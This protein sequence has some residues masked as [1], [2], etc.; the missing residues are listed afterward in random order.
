MQQ[1]QP[2]SFD[3]VYSLKN[4]KK[5][6]DDIACEAYLKAELWVLCVNSPAAS[7]LLAAIPPVADAD[8]NFWG[9]VYTFPV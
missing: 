7:T 6:D 5:Y 4:E 9:P 2:D 3:R 1:Q 8:P